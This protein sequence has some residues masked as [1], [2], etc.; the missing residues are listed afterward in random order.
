MD[1]VE[2]DTLYHKIH[3]KFMT[4]NEISFYLAEIISVLQYLHSNQIIYR[5]IK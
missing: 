4:E 2:G 1:L 3:K 5:Y